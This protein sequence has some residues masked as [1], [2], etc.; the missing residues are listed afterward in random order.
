MNRYTK[1]GEEVPG[2]LTVLALFAV[3]AAAVLLE[4]LVY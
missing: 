1:T 2:I 3:I 4:I